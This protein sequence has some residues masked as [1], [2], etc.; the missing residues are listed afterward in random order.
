MQR[1]Q[2][3]GLSPRGVQELGGASRCCR[4]DCNA[5]LQSCS[6]LQPLGLRLGAWPAPV[7]VSVAARHVRAPHPLGDNSSIA[8][9][10]NHR[11]YDFM[12]SAN[13]DTHVQWMCRDCRSNAARKFMRCPS[14][15]NVPCSVCDLMLR[16]TRRPRTCAR[17]HEKQSL[18][19][20]GA[21]VSIARCAQRG[22]ICERRHGCADS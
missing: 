16:F 9:N 10:C 22:R 14:S 19:L 13:F 5:T 15:V 12:N 18:L 7:C 21:P 2:C 3:F 1:P 11:V 8:C 17:K 6:H 20:H 4:S